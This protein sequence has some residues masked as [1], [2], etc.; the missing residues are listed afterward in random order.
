MVRTILAWL[1]FFGGMGGVDGRRPP[2]ANAGWRRKDRWYPNR[3]VRP[4]SHYL[5]SGCPMVGV[6]G[7]EA[8]LDLV[9]A[10]TR[11]RGSGGTRL[12]PV[13]ADGNQLCL[14]DRNRLLLNIS[15]MS[16]NKRMEADLRKRALPARSAAH[17]RRYACQP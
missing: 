15:R 10:F 1:L 13:C 5:G 16:S 17:A 3:I 11:C 7:Y 2:I 4:C 9:E 12:R 14:S 8:S 6:H